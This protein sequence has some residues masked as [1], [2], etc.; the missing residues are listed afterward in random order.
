M[1]HLLNTHFIPNNSDLI[2]IK[3]IETA[4]VVIGDKRVNPLT[5]GVAYIRVFTFY[6]HIQY[7]VLNMLKIKSTFCQI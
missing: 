6:W 2:P 3:L 7:N 1:E 5:A 4:V